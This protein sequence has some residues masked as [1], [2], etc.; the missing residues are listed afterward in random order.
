VEPKKGMESRSRIETWLC[1]M[2]ESFGGA[3]AGGDAG[4]H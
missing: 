1:G 2:V 3:L 4:V